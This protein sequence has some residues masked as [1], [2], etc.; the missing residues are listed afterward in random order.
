MKGVTA[1]S[2]SSKRSP[3]KKDKKV[4]LVPKN[5]NRT[6]KELSFWKS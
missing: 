5:I 6:I 2:S 3:K 4:K 1:L